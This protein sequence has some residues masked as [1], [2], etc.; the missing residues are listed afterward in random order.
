MSQ[1]ERKRLWEGRDEE[2]RNTRE[3]GVSSFNEIDD[4]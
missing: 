1:K 2:R 3:E 4:N